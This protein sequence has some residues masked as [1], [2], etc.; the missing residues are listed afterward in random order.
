[1]V[2]GLIA[3]LAKA[4]GYPQEVPAE[5]ESFDFLVDGEVIN[6]SCSAAGVRALPSATEGALLVFQ[7]V[8]TEDEEVAGRLTMYAAGRLMKE[9][10]VLAWDPEKRAAI[11]W[12]RVKRSGEGEERRAF[13]SFCE[14][15]D[16]W[17]ERVKEEGRE[18]RGA[19]AMMIRP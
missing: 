2:E 8:L 13:E 4:I 15:A 16:W 14:S 11:L 19:P 9:T 3:R 10:A 7:T 5:A 1:M 12:E 18:V 17:R 6:V